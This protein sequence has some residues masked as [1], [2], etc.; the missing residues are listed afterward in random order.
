MSPA[1]ALVGGQLQNSLLYG[2]PGGAQAVDP[3]LFKPF[4]DP[5]LS[6]NPWDLLR[7][8]TKPVTG[9]SSPSFSI[10]RF[11]RASSPVGHVSIFPK[12]S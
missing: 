11:A 8:L 10:L 6:A 3:I 9:P 12:K 2:D 1:P 4:S 7:I 5:R